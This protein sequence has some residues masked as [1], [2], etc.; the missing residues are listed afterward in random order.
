MRWGQTRDFSRCRN[1][2]L[3]R[4]LGLLTLGSV[5]TD[6][7]LYPLT[8]PEACRQFL[9]L[10]LVPSLPFGINF[11]RVRDHCVLSFPQVEKP[12]R[13]GVYP[14]PS[15]HQKNACHTFQTSI[16]NCSHR[17]ITRAVK[18]RVIHNVIIRSPPTHHLGS[19]TPLEYRDL[20]SPSATPMPS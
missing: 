15:T 16:S 4:F 9:S 8:C 5:L 20:T 3:P 17:I 13:R 1:N 11:N 18:C 7:H 14:E 6:P 2:F 10:I 19:V 12:F